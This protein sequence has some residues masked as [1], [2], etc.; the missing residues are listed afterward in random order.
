M[1]HLEFWNNTFKPPKINDEA[2]DTDSYNDQLVSS[3]IR[4]KFDLNKTDKHNDDL[5]KYTNKFNLLKPYENPVNDIYSEHSSFNRKL[6][7]VDHYIGDDKGAPAP[8]THD[9]ELSNLKNSYKSYHEIA[10]LVVKSDQIK[11]AQSSGS[12]DF[13]ANFMKNLKPKRELTLHEQRTQE[14]L[15]YV[16]KATGEVVQRG[17][18]VEKGGWGSYANKQE[19]KVESAFEK[20]K[21][22]VL[23]AFGSGSSR[24]AIRSDD[25]SWGK[26]E[27]QTLSNTKQSPPPRYE[28]PPP[29]KRVSTPSEANRSKSVFSGEK[30]AT[31]PQ[32]VRDARQ[33]LFERSP[34]SQPLTLAPSRST[35]APR[36]RSTSTFEVTTPN[37]Q[38][39]APTPTQSPVSK[40]VIVDEKDTPVVSAKAVV[41]DVVDSSFDGY[42]QQ[43][44]QGPPIDR[45]E[46]IEIVT[47]LV[48]EMITEAVNR[49]NGTISVQD[50]QEIVDVVKD[51]IPV[52]TPKKDAMDIVKKAIR[53]TGVSAT[54]K[55]TQRS[56]TAQEN[57]RQEGERQLMEIEDEQ[58]KIYENSLQ[59][60]KPAN[61]SVKVADK[62]ADEESDDSSSDELEEIEGE[63]EYE[64]SLRRNAKRAERIL[65]KG[66]EVRENEEMA[67]EDEYGLMA[68]EDERSKKLAKLEKQKKQAKQ[69]AG[70]GGG[71]EPKKPAKERSN[72]ASRSSSRLKGDDQEDKSSSKS[73]SRVSTRSTTTTRSR[74]E[75]ETDIKTYY[76]DNTKW[77]MARPSAKSFETYLP[78]VTEINVRSLL[79][80][81]FQ[82]DPNSIIIS[83]KT[84]TLES[85][86][87]KPAYKNTLF[88][89]MATELSTRGKKIMYD[90][91]RNEAKIF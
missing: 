18:P 30:R 63:N 65:R 32:H 14:G 22:K 42:K 35:S 75:E 41:K 52:S 61:R 28:S 37:A 49:T 5:V 80:G 9:Y 73:S 68:R 17:T 4:F 72:T 33:K 36:S 45:A 79:R 77:S 85:I 74:I 54:K 31:T 55:K 8:A 91:T 71:A 67:R 19:L 82:L 24:S 47:S 34:I 57:M 59:K 81:T 83:G 53:S 10:D 25:F 56:L 50:I 76:G 40:V 7:F 29:N 66:A 38:R 43:K 11:N 48:E 84:M 44:H 20:P 27:P 12:K 51:E 58:S 86:L 21:Q 69:E 16:K 39:Q 1:S 89:K 15:K 23:G 87:E 46:T 62:V 2:T 78:K 6:S 64:R 88:K 13:A 3:K 60:R 26:E 70:A 90:E